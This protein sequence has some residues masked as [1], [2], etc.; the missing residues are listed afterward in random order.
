[1]SW[2]GTDD[3]GGSGIAVY[4]IFVS[5]NGGAF[6]LWRAG[7]SETVGTFTGEAGHTYGFYSVA[8]DYTGHRQPTPSGPQAT[9]KIVA[10]PVEKAIYLPLVLRGH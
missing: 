6:G 3:P 7:I 4:D 10:L 5:D 1:V 8:A 9:T 2:S